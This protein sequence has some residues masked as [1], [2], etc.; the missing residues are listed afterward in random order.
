MSSWASVLQQLAELDPSDSEP[1]AMADEQLREFI[2]LAQ[3]GINRLSA[4]QTRA[5]GAG[6]ARQVHTGDGM[7]AMK[8]WLIGHCRLS[9]RDAAGLVRA[10]GRLK[11]LPALEA[12]YAAGSVTPAHVAAITTGVTP[13]RVAKAADLG[14]DLDHTDRIL[15]QAALALGPE[16]T[17]QAVRRWVLGVDPDGTLDDDAGRL[18]VFRLAVSGGGRTYLSGHLDP[19]GAETVHAALEAVINDPRPAGDR[20]S[21]P[22]RQGDALVELCRQALHGGHLPE[23]RGQRPHVR[24]SI[25]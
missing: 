6:E 5:V 3:V 11:G 8:S 2:P 13:A 23:V 7:T 12:A 1:D 4:L 17:A 25:D 20:R 22:E 16:D 10:A 15:T 24:V 9:G 19:V 14:I 21:H 18:R